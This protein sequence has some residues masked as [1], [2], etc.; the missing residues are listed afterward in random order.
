MGRPKGST[1]ATPSQLRERAKALQKEAALKE[2]ISK[3]KKAGSC[4]RGA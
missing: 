4:Q 1:N 2:R 3:L